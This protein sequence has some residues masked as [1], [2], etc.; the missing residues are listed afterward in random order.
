MAGRRRGPLDALMKGGIES[1]RH[2]VGSLDGKARAILT[3]GTIVLGIVMGGVG[4]VVGLGGGVSWGLPGAH[5]PKVAPAPDPGQTG[6]WAHFP[7]AGPRPSMA[8]AGS[9]SAR[10]PT[11]SRARL[12]QADQGAA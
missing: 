2:A 8:R 12:K 4:T 5:I 11:G 1:H 3:A 9:L 10:F 6:P 7:K